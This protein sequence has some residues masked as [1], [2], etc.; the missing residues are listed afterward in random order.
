MAAVQTVRAAADDV[1]PYERIPVV[2]P[3][4]LILELGCVMWLYDPLGPCAQHVCPLGR[5]CVGAV[6]FLPVAPS[7]PPGPIDSIFA[8]Q[9]SDFAQREQQFRGRI[10]RCHGTLRFSRDQNRS[11]A[12]MRSVVFHEAS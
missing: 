10:I 3:H 5:W 7:V 11:R 4:T 12:G 1:A 8:S 6:V 9:W 2:V